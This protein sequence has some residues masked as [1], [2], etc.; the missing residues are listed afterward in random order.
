MSPPIKRTAVAFA[1]FTVVFMLCLFL[2]LRVKPY[3]GK[4]MV[5]LG[6]RIAAMAIDARVQECR[7]VDKGT[8]VRI[9]YFT[10]VLKGVREVEYRDTLFTDR[11]T[12]NV[13][14]TLSLLAAIMTLIRL[15][16]SSILEGL[17]LIA[18]GHLIWIISFLMVHVKTFTIQHQQWQI[19]AGPDMALQFLWQFS[20]NML[21]RF[22]PFIIPAVL[23]IVHH[24]AGL[25]SKK[26]DQPS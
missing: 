1:V 17:G 22:E 12:F 10:P 2:W 19:T 25:M 18:A 4:A 7:R 23:W 16:W 13:P 9:T 26:E 8:E 14:L 24:G 20:D 6:S 5:S 21:I 3:Y 15:P 11:Y